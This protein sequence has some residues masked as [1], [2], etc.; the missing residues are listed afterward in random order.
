M[1]PNIKALI[2]TAIG[3]F[4][5][6]LGQIVFFPLFGL[7]TLPI[8]T[9]LVLGVLFTI[10]AYIGNV[11]G[12]KLIDYLDK[13]LNNKATMQSQQKENTKNEQTKPY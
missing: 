4:V 6:V 12:L 10:L 1:N 7:G 3:Y 13:K 8:L 5:G 11:L 2:L 9:A